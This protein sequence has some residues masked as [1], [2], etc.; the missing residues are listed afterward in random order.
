MK[1]LVWPMVVVLFAGCVR[2]DSETRVERGPLLKTVPKE[3]VVEGGVRGRVLAG[4]PEMQISLE[5]FETCRNEVVETYEEEVITE[6][7]SPASGAALSAGIATTLAGGVLLALSPLFSGEPN[8]GVIDGAGRFGPAPRQQVTAWSI[9][10]MVVG[11]PA[12]AAGL[13]GLVRSGDEVES[14][15]VDQVAS[16]RDVPCH[17]HPVD[18]PVELWGEKGQVAPRRVAEGG[19]VT[20]KASELEGEV[21]AVKFHGRELLL[22]E[23]SDQALDAFASCAVLE[24]APLPSF[25]LVPSPKLHDRLE[26]VRACRA[27]RADAMA[28]ESKRI[29]AELAKRRDQGEPQALRPGANATSLAEAME[30][31][32]PT[33]QLVAGSKDVGML[34]APA[35]VEGKSAYLEAVVELAVAEN[36]A[37][38]KVGEQRAFL[39]LTPGAP[40]STGFPVGSPVQGVVV[41]AGLQTVGERSLPVLRAVYLQRKP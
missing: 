7:R 1:T 33:L 5:G 32:T 21:V 10:L 4:W 18:G 39:F 35:A 8:R 3:S 15:T 24:R 20:V 37:V 23:E 14:R 19:R 26:W 17:E 22:D 30:A 13:I 11:V 29:E 9:G 34:A 31:R 6:K 27:L 28:E 16:Q 40:W 12:I 2:V 25:E 36:I 38:V 41:V